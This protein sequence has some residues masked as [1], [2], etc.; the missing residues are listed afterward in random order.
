MKSNCLPVWAFQEDN[1]LTIENDTDEKRNSF[2]RKQ[3]KKNDAEIKDV[4]RLGT[5]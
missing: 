5:F 1:K 2:I 4:N 3:N